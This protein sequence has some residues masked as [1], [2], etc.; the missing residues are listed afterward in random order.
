ME[1]VDEL[2]RRLTA[3]GE[4]QIAGLGLTVPQAGL[5]HTL[6]SPL[7][8]KQIAERM[9]CDASN[10]TGIVDRLEDR[11][12]VERRV[13]ADDRR[14][15]EIALTREGR[16]VKRGSRHPGAS[17]PR[18]CQAVLVT[19]TDTSAWPCPI[20]RTADLIGDGWTL[21]ITREARLGSWAT[22]GRS[23]FTTPPAI[24]TCKQSSPAASAL[25]RGMYAA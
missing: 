1:Q 19:R 7:P 3:Y 17:R 12:L 20:A 15:K 22:T 2:H 18:R 21:L 24:T 11:G 16:R 6:G 13:R 5:L 23:Y 4:S 8:M 14:V 10:L 9:H 25:S